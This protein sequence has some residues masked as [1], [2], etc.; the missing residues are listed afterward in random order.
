MAGS[1]RANVIPPLRFVAVVAPRVASSLA[2]G[3]CA[4]RG[5]S[6]SVAHLV[7]YGL[8]S[9]TRVPL[10]YMSSTYWLR[11]SISRMAIF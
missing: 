10:L 11:V 2:I 1:S 8:N 9:E 3:T 6:H 4:R 5:V 7:S